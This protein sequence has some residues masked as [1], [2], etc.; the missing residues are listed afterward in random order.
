MK[1]LI[2][3]KENRGYDIVSGSYEKIIGIMMKKCDIVLW[4]SVKYFLRLF[5]G[6]IKCIIDIMEYL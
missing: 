2:W 3:G 6:V 1:R 4:I 5:V